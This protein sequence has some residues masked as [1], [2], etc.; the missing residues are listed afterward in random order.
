MRWVK[1]IGLV[2]GVLALVLSVYIAFLI[3]DSFPKTD[4]ELVVEGLNSKVEVIRDEWGIPYI[5]ADNTHDL[6]FAQ[7]YT[8]A[9]ERFWQMDFWRHIGA[10]RLTELFGEGIV[11]TDIFLRS[12]GFTRLAEEELAT[13]SDLSRSVLQSYADGVNAYL[14]GRSRSQVSFEYALLR[15][16]NSSYTIEPW[17]PIHTLTWGKLMSWDLSGN[18]GAELD[19]AELAAALPLER[20]EQ[21]YPPFPAGH[22]HIVGPEDGTAGSVPTAALPIPEAALGALEETAR[23]ARG[24]WALT[25]GGFEGIGSN[26]WVLSG[27]MTG[28]G[29]PLLANDTHLSIQMPGIW[30]SNGLHCR[31][32]GEDCPFNV[33]GVSFP[34]VPA[35][36]IGHN[37]R[38]AWGVTTQAVDTQDLFIERVDPDDPT[39]YE[40]E[41]EWVA[42][43]VRQETLSVAGGEDFTFEV[44]STRHGPVVSGVLFDDDFLDGTSAVGL[45][46]DYVVALAWESL[47]PS[48]LVEAVFGLNL[49][50]GYDDFREAASKWDIAAQNL[51][52]ADVEGN[53][54]YQSTGRVPI[55]PAG[56]GRYPVP[57]WTSEYTWTG[58]VP[59]EEMPFLLNP[60]SGFISTANQPVI[61]RE[62]H[63]FL[64]SDGDLGFRARRIVDMLA[65]SVGHTVETM[66]QMQMDN[67]HGGAALL[68]PHLLQ[69]DPAGDAGV[70]E[71]LEELGRWIGGRSSLQATGDS[72]GAAAFNAIW[73]HLLA[74][75]FHDDLP[76]DQ[77]PYGGARETVVVANLLALPDDP[78]WDD[79]TT[80][81]RVERRDDILH[82]SMVEAHAE[83][84]STFRDREEWSWGRMHVT[85]FRSPTFGESGIGLIEWFFNRTAPARVGGGPT[86][87]NAVGWNAAE[88]YR[89]DWIPAHRMVIDLGDFGRS[90]FLH[91]TGQSGH[92]FH[93]HFDDMI[94]AWVDGVQAPMRW[95]PADIEASARS[96]L[97][98]LPR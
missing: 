23:R 11:D 1:R 50:T 10:G 26:S 19:R 51:V 81:E 83:L 28:S 36:V 93:R 18:M 95:D 8:H 68:V 74:N 92:A 98:L 96:T 89:T 31:P 87:V 30:F 66:Q 55:R 57:G 84:S 94:E 77:R 9:Q 67:F 82:R 22:P 2:V 73:R 39:R 42:F 29:M 24:L 13:M 47:R 62:A 3:R 64:T 14:D 65:G 44:R 41:G 86:V 17:E 71:L 72:S 37:D 48:T 91:T 43:E 16:Q 76:E 70:V 4:G 53:I 58:S 78:Y 49:A 97:V 69:V 12:M 25:G 21:L 6:F 46:A 88:G 61:P 27:S 38:I 52:Y 33:V 40:V 7:G 56:D 20:V 15:L 5:F 90:S 80:T 54:A 32:L 85:E 79:V 75:L 59:F 35:V 63:P 45:P 60:P 34:G